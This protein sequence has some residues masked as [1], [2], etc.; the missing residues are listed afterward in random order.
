MSSEKRRKDG[1]L[2]VYSDAR[3]VEIG[4]AI[5]SWF[6]GLERPKNI[7]AQNLLEVAH[8]SI[9]RW[10]NGGGPS[11][12]YMA[13]LWALTQNPTFLLSRAEKDA[14]SKGNKQV[15]SEDFPD[16]EVKVRASSA[17]AAKVVPTG[18]DQS[19]EVLE[20]L[21]DLK[22]LSSGATTKMVTAT[23]AIMQGGLMQ[24]ESL[25]S[26]LGVSIITA[27]TKQRAA[28]FAM[29]LIQTLAL[30][31][32]DLQAHSEPETDPGRLQ[33]IESVLSNLT[34]KRKGATE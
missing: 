4:E 23:M 8:R 19:P 30:S 32:E 24:L 26:E 14:F 15:P 28:L 20:F 7:T 25:V 13:R 9:Y 31:R 34:Q 33:E 5:S 2:S 29:R 18:L 16:R 3:L 1:R 11:P 22:V 17:T 27:S 21:K 12:I 10:R 6:S